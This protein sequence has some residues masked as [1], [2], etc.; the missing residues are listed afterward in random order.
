VLIDEPV[1]MYYGALMPEVELVPASFGEVRYAVATAKGQTALRDALDDAL[2]ALA[3]EGKLRSIYER[4]GLW[5]AE[6]AALLHDALVP[7][8]GS[9]AAYDE[10]RST[11]ASGT[12]LERLRRYASYWPQ[13][14]DGALMTLAVSLAAFAGAVFW[15]AV[16]AMAR[17]YGPPPVRWAAV[18]YI[19]VFRGTP[20]LVQLYFIYFGLPELGITLLPFKAGVLGLALNYA[21]A[22]AENY[23]A[24][25]ES[26]PAGQLEASW[27][28]GLSTFQAVLHVIVPQAVRVAIPPATNDFIALLKDSS[29]VSVITMTELLR[30]SGNL[31]SAT[32]DS[33]GMYAICAVIYL[34]LGL[35]F[36]RLARYV[37]KRM[38][39]HLRRVDA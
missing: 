36:A 33:R 8:H 30:V 32:R 17:R 24:G 39:A 26:V 5:N 7:S 13:F 37:E 27:A 20:L 22:E 34:L 19:E 10:W 6:T 11:K 14:L 18:A 15:G 4:W 1:A 2:D 38:S 3:R 31:A 9:H 21:A 25:L 29:L 23:R 16:L 28:L 12:W 35:P